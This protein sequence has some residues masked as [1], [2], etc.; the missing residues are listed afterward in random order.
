MAPPPHASQFRL[1]PNP[2]VL[3]IR[4]DLHDLAPQA[5]S[6]GHS[7]VSGRLV[8]EVAV[9][10]KDVFLAVRVGE[11]CRHLD[12]GRPQSPI[13]ESGVLI[14]GH[15]DVVELARGRRGERVTDV[16]GRTA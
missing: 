7:E 1:N 15:D 16:G 13:Q 11:S 5:R 14:D 4:P 6:Q 9:E 3:L 2:V 10:F 12:G 8:E